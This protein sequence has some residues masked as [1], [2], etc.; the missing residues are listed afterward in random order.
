[1]ITTRDLAWT[2]GFLDGEGSFLWAGSLRVVATQV[3]R[4]ALDRLAML[5]GGSVCW[6]PRPSS[7]HGIHQWS[8]SGRRAGGLMLTL[9]TMMS[10]KRRL[11]IRTAIDRWRA[12]PGQGRVNRAKTLCPQGHPYDMKVYRPG[13]VRAE[14]RCRRCENV[15]RQK[16]R[17]N[18][19]SLP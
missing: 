9:Y 4:W 10:L 14:R 1:M 6:C 19:R 15:R 16:N 11:Q 13:R 2:A 5:Y 17:M 18:L 12:R 3:D 8:L 7:G